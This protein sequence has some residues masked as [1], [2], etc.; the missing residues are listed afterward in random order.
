MKDFKKKQ[1][2]KTVENTTD[3]LKEIN[4]KLLSF[5]G[6][7]NS[8]LSHIE[9][10]GYLGEGTYAL[11]NLAADSYRKVLVALKIFDKKTLIVK[12]RLSNLLVI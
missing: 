10:K 11:V 8:P 7:E 2:V 3:K 9:I 12:R 4:A 6:H 5:L 1:E